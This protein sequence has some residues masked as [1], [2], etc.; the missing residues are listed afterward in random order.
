M[1]QP[2]LLT[3][4]ESALFLRLRPSTMRSW[5]LQR[6]IPHLKLG[7]R[8]FLRRSDLEELLRK[9]LVP[10]KQRGGAA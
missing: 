9:S 2:D 5:L 1:D 6:R 3:V 8:V 4:V 10:A 7:G